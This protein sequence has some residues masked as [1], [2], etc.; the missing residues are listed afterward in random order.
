MRRSAR[1]AKLSNINTIQPIPL[2]IE[3]DNEENRTSTIDENTSNNVNTSSIDEMLD[4][5]LSLLE[6]L[7][8][9]I[10]D[11]HICRP[12][13]MT[14]NMTMLQA[15]ETFKEFFYITEEINKRYVSR[16]PECIVEGDTVNFPL[17]HENSWVFNMYV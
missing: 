1:R 13:E 16:L 15:K 9:D 10:N 14:S 8:V 12:I 11:N 2:R 5:S 3:N 7:D 6:H 4:P 17:F